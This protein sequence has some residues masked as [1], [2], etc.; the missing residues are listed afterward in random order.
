M[1]LPRLLL[2]LFAL[3]PALFFSSTS[4]TQQKSAPAKAPVKT[5][6]KAPASTKGAQPQ[7]ASKKAAS[8]QS[9]KKSSRTTQARSRRPATQQQPDQQRVREI[10][11]A[12]SD[13]GYPLDVS[14]V[15]GPQSVDA[16]KKFQEDQNINN[17]SGRGKLD[18]L[19]LIALGL[20]PRREPPP[21]P[22]ASAEKAATE[23]KQQ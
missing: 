20:G 17:L 12:L 13:K 3:L 21:Q 18:S 15:W 9:A 11:Q 4:A 23:G 19:T 5:P 2:V 16:L 7:S 1:K 6:P 8:K 10:Q 14:G 22:A